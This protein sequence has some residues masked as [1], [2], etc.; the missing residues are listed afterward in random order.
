MTYCMYNVK[1]VTT[2][3]LCSILTPFSSLFTVLMHSDPCWWINQWICKSI[4]AC[5][6]CLCCFL[7]LRKTSAA[8]HTW[9]EAGDGDGWRGW[10]AVSIPSCNCNNILL[11]GIQAES[12]T[13][14]VVNFGSVLLFLLCCLCPGHFIVFDVSMALVGQ[15]HLQRGNVRTHLACLAKRIYGDHALS[16]TTF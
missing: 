10:A 7:K 12:K 15:W 13:V 3:A 1:G 6:P 8:A 5:L 2:S 16:N 9:K 4:I 11:S 14:C